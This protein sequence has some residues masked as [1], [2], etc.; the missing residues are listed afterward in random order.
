M[1]KCKKKQIMLTVGLFQFIV[2]EY[3]P[4]RSIRRNLAE[5]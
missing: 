5:L 2:W 3:N 1:P 4:V